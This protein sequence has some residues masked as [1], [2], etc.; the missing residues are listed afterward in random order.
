MEHILVTTDLS[1][2]S[3]AGLRFAIQLSQQR[4]IKLT[5]FHSYNVL[6]PMAWNEATF[7]EYEKKVADELKAELIKFVNAVYREI[8][9]EPG[10]HTCVIERAVDTDNSIIDYAQKHKFNYICLSTRGAGR[11]KKFFGTN[12]SFLIN[13]SPIPVIAVPHTYRRCKISSI[14]YA[15]DLVNL[16][17]EL[18]KVVKFSKPLEAKV[19][20]LHFNYQT[21]NN[22][23]ES[24]LKKALN[25]FSKHDIELKIDNIILIDSLI[26]NI[27]IAINRSKPSMMVMFTE[28]NRSFFEKIFISSNAAEYSFNATLP[29]LVFNK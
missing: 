26:S 22:T 5:F 15:S 24:I 3:K 29:L 1:T 6:K 21:D 20:L 7:N 12:T 23:K 17:N 25:K 2:K 4:N 27:E 10:H 19:E 18:Q 13:H 14:L 8:D 16:E 28:Q 9:V 11:I